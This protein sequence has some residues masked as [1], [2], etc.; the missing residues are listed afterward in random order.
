MLLLEHFQAK[1]IARRNLPT[2]Y[3]LYNRLVWE[4]RP[5]PTIVSYSA[6]VVKL[7]TTSSLVRVL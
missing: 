5:N 4:Y 6:S 3:L 1:K 7:N 2:D